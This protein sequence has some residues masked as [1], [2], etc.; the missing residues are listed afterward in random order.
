MYLYED[1]KINK[2]CL[3]LLLAGPFSS[4]AIFTETP[5]CSTNFGCGTS[6]FYQIRDLQSSGFCHS[7]SRGGGFWLVLLNCDYQALCSALEQN[8]LA[9]VMLEGNAKGH[10]GCFKIFLPGWN[11]LYINRADEKLRI[12]FL[13]V[14]RKILLFC[15]SGC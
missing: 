14:L 13:K 12:I 2:N 11:R 10:Q 7:G 9:E 5:K 6:I 4:S 3:L 8:T 1:S 15:S